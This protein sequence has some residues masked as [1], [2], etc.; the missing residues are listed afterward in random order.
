MI[1]VLSHLGEEMSN[2]LADSFPQLDLIVNGHR[3][4]TVEPVR[5]R[6]NARIIHFSHL[7]QEVY[8]L[9][10]RPGDRNSPEF[11]RHPVAVSARTQPVIEQLARQWAAIKANA[12]I[13][14]DLYLMSQCPYGRDALEVLLKVSNHLKKRAALNLYFIISK[15]KE[16]WTSLHGQSELDENLRQAVIA[17]YR[18]EALGSYLSCML[19]KSKSPVCLKEAGIQT[20][21]LDG[22]IRASGFRILE[23]HYARTEKLNIHASP[24]LYIDNQPYEAAIEEQS[25]LRAL[26]SRGLRGRANDCDNVP[27]C[28]ADRDCRAPGKEGKCFEPGTQQSRCIFREAP[29][30]DLTVITDPAMVCPP[31]I[32]EVLRS[33]VS[34]LPGAKIRRF[35]NSNKT[36]AGI[37]ARH[38]ITQLPAMLLEKGAAQSQDFAQLENALEPRSDAYLLKPGIVRASIFY[39]RPKTPGNV[40]LFVSPLSEQGNAIVDR[41]LGLA[42]ERSQSIAKLSIMPILER[43]GDSVEARNG[44]AEFEEAGRELA[45]SDSLRMRYLDR[46]RPNWATSYWEEAVQKAGLDPVQLKKAA[47]SA[48]TGKKLRRAAA[49]FAEIGAPEFPAVFLIDN[50]EV[51]QPQ[52]EADLSRILDYL[53]K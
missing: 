24:T 16:N 20:Q 27:E 28:I 26:C 6:G 47:Q 43:K 49:L 34:I 51:V 52:N 3:K 46:R 5:R 44:L 13:R 48:E 4:T 21:D 19:Q 50:R 45:M 42:R 9:R 2:A 18:P 31:D 1:V 29:K 25:L 12:P 41:F 17:A 40:V 7:G 35:T 22:L 36:A 53:K 11:Q 8:S 39:K 38:G 14:L 37:L 23:S 10:L 30:F 32:E 15:E 33:T